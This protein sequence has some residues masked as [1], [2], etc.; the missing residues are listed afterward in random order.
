MPVIQLVADQAVYKYIEE[1]LCED[2]KSWPRVKGVLGGFHTEG[3]YINDLGKRYAC[4]GLQELAIASGAVSEGSACRAC[5]GKHYNRG[6][7]IHK[8]MS[9]AI[10]RMLIQKYF[11]QHDIHINDL[12]HVVNI[13]T[14]EEHEEFV[15]SD[16]FT[17]FVQYMFF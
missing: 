8:L 10:F 13:S 15:K 16:T 12:R 11:Q 9:N 3:S 4:S 5:L 17:K 7:R 1:L 2:V 14:E 6:M